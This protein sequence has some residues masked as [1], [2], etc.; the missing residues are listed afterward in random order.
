MTDSVKIHET[1]VLTVVYVQFVGY[2]MCSFINEPILKHCNISRSHR[3]F[4]ES[5]WKFG[6]AALMNNMLNRTSTETNNEGLLIV[7]AVNK[8]TG[9]EQNGTVCKDAFNWQSAKSIC[10]SIGY[11]FADW[12]SGQINLKSTSK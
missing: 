10:R 9:I 11:V 5:L 3:C 1:Q 12:G 8:Q 2:Y 4:T 7:T 6:K